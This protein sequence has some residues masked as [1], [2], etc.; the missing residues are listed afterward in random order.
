MAYHQNGVGV[1][2]SCGGC[3]TCLRAQGNG[4]PML[5]DCDFCKREIGR[6]D[7]AGCNCDLCDVCDRDIESCICC[8]DCNTI[9]GNVFPFEGSIGCREGMVTA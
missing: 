9:C 5:I 1:E 3:E 4:G 7:F 6:D 8:E 2:C